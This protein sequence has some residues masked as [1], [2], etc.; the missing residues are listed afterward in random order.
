MTF[1]AASS[2]C[3]VKPGSMSRMRLSHETL[4]SPTRPRDD[5]RGQRLGERRKL[6]DRIGF[7]RPQACRSH[8]RQR[9]RAGR[10]RRDGRARST[11]PGTSFLVDDLPREFLELGQAAATFSL[12]AVC[13]SAGNGTNSA[14]MPARS[15]RRTIGR[16]DQRE[17]SWAGNIRKAHV[18]ERPR[19]GL[20]LLMRPAMAAPGVA[21]CV[22]AMLMPKRLRQ[23]SLRR[24]G[25]VEA[26]VPPLLTR[27]DQS[28]HGDTNAVNPAQKRGVSCS[29]TLNGRPCPEVMLSAWPGGQGYRQKEHRGEVSMLKIVVAALAAVFLLSHVEAQAQA[30]PSKPIRFVIPS[31]R[32]RQ[33]TPLARIAG[34]ELEQI[35]GQP[36]IVVP[37][38]GADGA[39]ARHRGQAR[40]A[41]RL[42]LSCS[43]PTARS[44][45]RRTCRRSRPT[46]S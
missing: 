3:S 15:I 41:R 5:R 34:Q 18:R 10:P 4:P 38:P 16:L 29:A 14:A 25:P 42:H 40:G 33:P 31:A 2:S 21:S 27:S 46:T 7:R 44:P 45:S 30:Y 12:V 26:C 9:R 24:D 32:A 36:I 35:L 20:A 28:R 37:K 13:A 1:A 8:A 6:E 43:A 22:P 39:L 17:G 19:W 23:Q 11:S